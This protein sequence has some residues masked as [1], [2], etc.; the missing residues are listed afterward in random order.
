M[1]R[2]SVFPLLRIRKHLTGHAF[3]NV[4]YRNYFYS[5]LRIQHQYSSK[6]P[7]HGTLEEEPDSLFK[8]QHVSQKKMQPER[9][10]CAFL[11]TVSKEDRSQTQATSEVTAMTWSESCPASSQKPSSPLLGPRP[12]SQQP[13][14]RPVPSRK[15][16]S[17]PVFSFPSFWGIK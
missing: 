1:I 11:L 9:K 14:P 8:I 12:R 5:I 10:G 17:K 7:L 13:A 3:W 15:E 6:Y 2:G 4:G 16:D